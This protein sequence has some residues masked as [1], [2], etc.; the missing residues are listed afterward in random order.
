MKMGDRGRNL[1]LQHHGGSPRYGLLLIKQIALDEL[2]EELVPVQLTNHG[3]GVVVICN[4]GGI[5]GQKVPYDLIDGV[6]TLF[7]EGVEN[8]TENPMHVFAV[9]TGD[10]E[11]NGVV[12]QHGFL[13]LC[14]MDPSYNKREAK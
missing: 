13:L 14:V 7:A 2:L 11:L 4:I 1:G 3:A 9:I 8:R 12:V 10:G 5:F 6:V